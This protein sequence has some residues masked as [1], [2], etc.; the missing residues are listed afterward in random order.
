MISKGDG[1]NNKEKVMKNK[2]LIVWQGGSEYV[3]T[4][5]RA[6]ETLCRNGQR[7]GK[8]YINH[9][10]DENLCKFVKEVALF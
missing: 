4:E 8:L 3:N 1:K 5:D 9:F 7:T 6:K 10:T 2:Y